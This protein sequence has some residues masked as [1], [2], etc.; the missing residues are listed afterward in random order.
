[1][2]KVLL[3][4]ELGS[5]LGH[6][7][8]L[9]P[10]ANALHRLG[11][12]PVL[13][14]ARVE[15]TRAVWGSSGFEVIGAPRF[16]HPGVSPGTVE[17]KRTYADVLIE[18]GNFTVDRLVTMGRAW[19]RILS[20]VKPD[21]VIC[22]FAPNLA[23][24][25]L[26]RIPTVTIGVGY[27]VPPAGRAF[28]PVRFWDREPIDEVGQR[29]E[30]GLLDNINVAGSHLGLARFDYAADLFGGDEVFVCCLPE[31]DCYRDVRTVPAIGSITS[32][33]VSPRTK[34]GSGLFGYLAPDEDA[35]VW[36]EAIA[37]ANIDASVFVRGGGRPVRAPQSVTMLDQPAD[38][39]QVLP[40]KALLIHHGGMGT[41]ETALRIGIPQLIIPTHFEQRLTARLIASY[42]VGEGVTRAN[43][44]EPST[45]AGTIARTAGDKDLNTR[46]RRMANAIATR[47]T[48]PALDVIV[49]AVGKYI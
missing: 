4:W 14:L 12:T 31:L 30:A 13:A 28:P 48:T 17:N 47:K 15:D 35:S 44:R 11:H 40:A 46:S 38:L 34:N 16:K 8:K 2:A 27:C 32:S 23:M 39:R 24:H 20:E 25:A 36:L 33:D 19:Q 5:G 7:G 43:A 26:R 42:G 3:G 22:D 9:M 29:N 37:A 21:L 49:A 45:L 6:I 10:L 18:F 41:T 1:M